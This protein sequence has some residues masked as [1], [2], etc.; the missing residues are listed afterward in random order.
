MADPTTQAMAIEGGYDPGNLGKL[1]LMGTA[2]VN[3]ANS[4][5]TGAAQV[6][7]GEGYGNTSMAENAK[8]AEQARQFNMTPVDAVQNGQPAFGTRA[9]VVAP[10]STYTPQ[11]SD[12]NFK[13]R[14]LN[15]NWNNLDATTPLQQQ[16]MGIAPKGQ[17]TP[18]NYV[19]PDGVT[20]ITYDGVT[21]SQTGQKLPGGGF[22]A[23]AQGAAKDVGLGETNTLKTNL[24][25]AI[26]NNTNFVTQAN[27]MVDLAKNHPEAFG[28]VGALRGI[29]QEAMQT[30]ST[31]LNLVGGDGAFKQAQQAAANAGLQKVLPEMYDPNLPKA[32]AAYYVLL[33]NYAS[34]LT[35]QSG[36]SVS[37]KDIELAQRALGNPDDLFGSANNFVTKVQTAAEI[38]QH[39][40]DHSRFILKNGFNATDPSD[41]QVSGNLEKVSSDL[42]GTSNTAPPVTAPG[43]PAAP[44]QGAPAATGGPIQ[45]KDAAGYNALPPGTHYIDPSG[46]PRVKVAQ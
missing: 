16:A 39:N 38:A 31:L 27:A 15:Q 10:G 35:G 25:T 11:E 22:I 36:R 33:Y 42:A 7:T 1:G 20:H 41:A 37:D 14:E 19:A 5:I 28:P 40:T 3:G 34:A 29:G 21:D 26:V 46:Q 13:G 45:I 43:G 12:S 32:R 30:G 23:N 17:S 24:E 44:A 9:S 4:P 2:M 18:H 6:A 8:L